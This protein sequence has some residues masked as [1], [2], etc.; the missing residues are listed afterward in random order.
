MD[1]SEV[2]GRMPFNDHLGIELIEIEDGYA[3]GILELSHEHSS[4]PDR[5][6]A[7]GGV[8]YALADTVGGAAVVAANRTVTPTI[9]MRIDYL[10]PATGETLRAEAHVVRNGKS[11]A[12]VEVTVTDD[13]RQEIATARG[14]YK[15]GGAGSESAWG[16]GEIDEA[17][18]AGT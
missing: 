4:R 3:L 15:S 14:V 12:T 16:H 7:H 2:F 9:D 18:S 17:D 5:L 11:V 13:E 6:V 8:T 1:V 10:A